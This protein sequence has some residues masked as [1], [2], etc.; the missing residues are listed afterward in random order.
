MN[1]KLLIT[2]AVTT[3]TLLYSCNRPA[4]DAD[5]AASIISRHTIRFTEPPSH[6]PSQFSVDAPLLG[7][8]YMGV[9]LAGQP[10]KQTFYIAR[11][12]FWRLKSAHD[13]TYPAVLGKIEIS[14]PGIADAE[15]LVEQNLYDAS[16]EARFRKGDTTVIY[17]TFLAATDDILSVEITMEGKGELPGN[18]ELILAGSEKPGKFASLDP[19]LSQL[20]SGKR[21]TEYKDGIFSATRSFED[22]VDI[23]AKASMAL[24]LAGTN[25]SPS[26]E[27]SQKFT[28]K[29]GQKLSF[30]LATSSNFKS[31]D[32][33]QTAIEKATAATTGNNLNRLQK[34]HREWWRSYWEKSWV[35]IPDTA[36][37]RQYYLSL[38]GT[39]SCSR[40]PDFPP[41]LFGTWITQEPPAWMGDYHL[42]YNF[43]APFYALYSANR[44]E[45][46]E[47]FYSP[48]IAFIERGKYYSGKI[49]G[50]P[51]GVIY[52]V[53][54]GPL[55]IETTRWSDKMEKTVPTWREGGHIQHGGMFWG[56]KS[57]ASYCLVNIAFHYYRTYD[58]DF[59]RR[60][61]PF[62]KACATFWENYVK[63][64]NNRYVI[65]N[66]AIHEG[67]TLTDCNPILS[68][69]LVRQ[70]MQTAL[71]MSR[72][73]GEDTLRREKWTHVRDH[74]AR[75]PLMERDGKTV[76]RLT[77]R[78][79]ESFDG[80]SLALQHIYPGEQIGLSSPPEQL[81]IAR[82]TIKYKNFLDEN[83][84]NSI[85]PAAVRIGLHPDT[86]IRHLNSYVEH[87]F[88][89]G[90][91]K[92][93][94]HGVENW[95]TVPNTINEM[96]CMGHQDI[97]RLFPVWPRRKDA[98]FH[99]IRT[100]GA[101]LISA[102]LTDGLIHHVSIL[103]EKG[104]TLNLLNPWPGEKV[105]I[106]SGNNETI[107]QG[108]TLTITTAENTRY[109]LHPVK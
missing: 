34:Q 19:S 48:I 95:S 94:P 46:A 69:G 15:Y 102:S 72:Q 80:N 3:F 73:L 77:E 99:N 86:I 58:E 88:P 59:T 6:I 98:Q 37:E 101:F 32:P 16:T 5:R 29:H 96:L 108:D 92:N 81:E 63:W 106:K 4:T 25:N 51:D 10:E 87:T 104:K 23:P 91:Q 11:N 50:I 9:A 20:F 14:I 105:T 22:S 64:E 45:Q 66:D 1:K 75:F 82:N 83:A 97:I 56:Q 78:G 2:V 76:F 40:D 84:S 57:N 44:T 55:G 103:S 39:A 8:G 43:Q 53:G 27:T 52:P 42:N 74:I 68:L 65:Y 90:F 17:K 60:L 18:L 26:S 24:R 12:D 41:G 85:F 107:C 100:T 89:N 33:K 67:N 70:T 54:I 62:V 35:S 36:I 31:S 71:D 13:E 109:N 47:P 30:V 28:L 79:F 93:N 49:A 38:Y 7:N 21:E 61:Y